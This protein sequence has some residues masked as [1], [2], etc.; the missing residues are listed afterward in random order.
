MNTTTNIG[1]SKENIQRVA[2]ML[3][4]LL[5][6]ET[7]LY[8]KTRNFH[9]NVTGRNFYGLHL[10]LEKHY[11]ELE[12]MIDDAAE[13]IRQLGHFAVGTMGD[14]LKLTN[15]VEAGNH[16]DFNAKSM[17]QAL[18]EDH[19]T[20][21]CILRNDIL[22]DEDC[23]DAGTADFSTNLMEKHEKMAWMLRSHLEEK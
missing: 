2:D 16:Q 12:S 18:V 13:R 20:I 5:A 1:I 11:K 4:K 17:I 14:Y 7:V 22:K 9:W 8:I 19:E 3:N 21:I 23:R 10:L 6:D 15:L